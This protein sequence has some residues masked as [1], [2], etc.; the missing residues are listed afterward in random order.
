M[1]RKGE[2]EAM[3]KRRDIARAYGD[4]EGSVAVLARRFHASSR[5]VQAAIKHDV[6]WWQARIAE[7]GKGKVEPEPAASA[8]PPPTYQVLNLVHLRGMDG[9]P[10]YQVKTMAGNPMALVEGTIDDV[11]EYLRVHG[12]EV[13][14]LVPRGGGDWSDVLVR[15]SRAG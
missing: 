14:Q 1:V 5:T 9:K 12:C 13:L 6:A 7:I 2:I 10:G 3:R 4:K 11:L 15:R 8:A